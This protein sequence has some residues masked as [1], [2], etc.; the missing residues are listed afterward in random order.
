M[1]QIPSAQHSAENI[2]DMIHNTAE[3]HKPRGPGIGIVLSPPP[4][5][6]VKW[7]DIELTK[8]QLYISERCLVGYRREI[9]GHIVSATQN[10]AG[11]GGDASFASHN[12]DISNDYTADIIYTD[13]LKAGDR[14]SIFPIDGGQLYILGQKVVKL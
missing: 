14:V 4:D 6:R 3:D 5:I 1:E 10:R 7:N 2:V 13:T 11:G 9:R 8:E 12:H